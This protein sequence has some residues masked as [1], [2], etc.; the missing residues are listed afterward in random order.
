MEKGDYVIAAVAGSGPLVRG[1]GYVK[2]EAGEELLVTSARNGYG[3]NV[4]RSRGGSE[5]VFYVPATKVRASLRPVGQVPEGSIEAD[6]PR[7]QW[8]F[9]DAG[10]LADRLGLC[11]DYDRIADAIGFPGRM[12]QFTIKLSLSAD[13]EITAK[14]EARNKKQAEQKIREQFAADQSQRLQAI[15]A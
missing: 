11:K 5:R 2:F 15:S 7:I 3:F 10:R 14:V 4:K 6:D 1:Y 13:V 12:R 9:E 8:L